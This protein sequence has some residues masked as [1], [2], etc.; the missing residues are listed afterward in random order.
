MNFH[1]ALALLG[2]RMPAAR[3]PAAPAPLEQ[4]ERHGVRSCPGMLDA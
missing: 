3:R 1:L 4:P 2:R